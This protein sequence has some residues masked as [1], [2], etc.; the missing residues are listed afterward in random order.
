MFLSYQENKANSV[1]DTHSYLGINKLTG[2]AFAQK[3]YL[4]LL[5]L[6]LKS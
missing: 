3:V 2:N 6:C 1:V 5:L 4:F